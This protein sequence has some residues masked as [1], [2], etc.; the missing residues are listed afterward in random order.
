MSKDYQ[1]AKSFAQKNLNNIIKHMPQKL[2]AREDNIFKN[3]KNSDESLLDK[4][5]QIYILL[6][7]LYSF[8]RKYVPCKMGCSYCCHIEVSISSLEAAYIQKQTNR[9]LAP[10]NQATE[11]F[12]TP[13]PFLDNSNCSIY[14]DR[15]FV[16]RRHHALFDDPKWCSLDLC[17]KYKFPQVRFTE[18]ERSYQYIIKASGSSLFDIRQLFQR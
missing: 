17:S 2:A 9:K 10:N 11:F 7:D 12:G 4:L 8:L 14:L 3:I 13:C 6:D 15:P 5:K 1:A 18:I 16:C